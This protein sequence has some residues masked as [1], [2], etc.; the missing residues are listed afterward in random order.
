MILR[1]TG[2]SQG[3]LADELGVSRASV[4][5]WLKNSDSMLMSSK[6]AIADKFGF[7]VSFF[8][9]DLEQDINL[10]KVIFSMKNETFS[11]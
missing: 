11:R 9:Y 3:K 6:Q 7:P 4:N 2:W 1:I 10:Y 8:D 5:M